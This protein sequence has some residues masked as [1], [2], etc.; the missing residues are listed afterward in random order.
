MGIGVGNFG[1]V[2]VGS[3]IFYLRLRNPGIHDNTSNTLVAD[4]MSFK[5][6]MAVLKFH[7]AAV[8]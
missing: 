3:R 5:K 1:N 2:G 4:V 8:R 7:V 6:K